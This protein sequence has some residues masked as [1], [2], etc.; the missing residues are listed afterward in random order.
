[1]QDYV[2]REQFKKRQ[3][4]REKGIDSGI[5]KE[6]E[7]HTVLVLDH[8]QGPFA[9]IIIGWNFGFLTLL[10]ELLAHKFSK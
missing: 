10:I 1:M 6:K 3:N 5:V 7:S 9:V 8:F 4:D 2:L